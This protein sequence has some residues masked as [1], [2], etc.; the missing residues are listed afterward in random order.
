M[1]PL[2]NL[3]D[4]C[5]AE[6]RNALSVTATVPPAILVPPPV[7]TPTASGIT[8]MHIVLP[9]QGNRDYPVGINSGGTTSAWF[10]MPPTDRPMNFGFMYNSGAQILRTFDLRAGDITRHV[11]G[12]SVNFTLGLSHINV[13]AG[14]V[15]E[16]RVTNAVN[17]LPTGAAGGFFQ[18]Q[19][20]G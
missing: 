5:I 11:Q 12:K 13:P 20:Q 1:M 4:T 17:G 14:A 18:I 10:Q 3:S 2:V 7:V 19:R 8:G 16:M 6:L 15:V 9:E